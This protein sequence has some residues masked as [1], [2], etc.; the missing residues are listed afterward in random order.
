MPQGTD[1]AKAAGMEQTS[2]LVVV[3]DTHRTEDHGLTGRT[4]EAAR[5]AEVLA[6]TGDF[7]TAAVYEVFRAIPDR[8]YA[9]SGNN[10]EMALQRRLPAR[11]DFSAEG[12][13]V[14]LVH[15]HERST[16][17]LSLLGREVDADI[18]ASGHSHRPSVEITDEL[19]LLNPGSH[20]APRQY[21]P[22]H[23]ELERAPDGVYGR[24]VRPDGTVIEAFRI[25]RTE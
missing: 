1:G 2:M 10:D 25:D 19:T 20:A 24:I 18:V 5:S 12:L 6:H 15:G 14:A 4:R 11:T 17:A 3:G 22:A 16:Q 23:A 9:V 7:T 13:T 8:F 21:Q